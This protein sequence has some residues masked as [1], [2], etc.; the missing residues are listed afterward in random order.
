MY[1]RFVYEFEDKLQE[2]INIIDQRIL[3]YPYTLTILKEMVSRNQSLDGWTIKN[4]NYLEYGKDQKQ[5]S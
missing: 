1:T 3:C 4:L 5:R 2:D